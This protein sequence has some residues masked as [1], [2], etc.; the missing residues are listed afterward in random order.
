MAAAV[1]VRNRVHS[2]G[3]GGVPFTLATGRRAELSSMRVF[4][5]PAYVHVD[6]SQPRKLDDRAWQG[7]FVGYA[8]K[9][10]AW[11]VYIPAT[12]RV[13]SSRNVVFDETVVLSMGESNAE[14]RNDDEEDNIPRTM[15]SEEPD[16]ASGESP[17]RESLQHS[18]SME[19]ERDTHSGETPRLRYNLRSTTSSQ[20]CVP[21]PRYNLRSTRAPGDGWTAGSTGPIKPT[22]SPSAQEHVSYKQARRSPQSGEWEAAIKSEYD[23]LVSQKTWTS[24]TCPAGR[25]LV[26][27][28]SC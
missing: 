17:L 12:R 23:S 21:S 25:K 1:H 28:C 16:K 11:L 9:S 15:C 4:G 6:K 18:G 2:G 14:Q 3:A 7:V 26:G 24:V 13:V 27:G 10:P 8:S 20:Q 19:D 5:C 22:C